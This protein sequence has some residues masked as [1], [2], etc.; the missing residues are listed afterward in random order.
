LEAE[1]IEFHYFIYRPYFPKK[2]IISKLERLNKIAQQEEMLWLEIRAQNML[3]NYHFTELKEYEKGF[4]YYERVVHLLKGT[5]P[6]EFPLKTECLFVVGLAHYHFHDYEQAV[7]NFKNALKAHYKRKNDY[8][9]LQ[10]LN[11]VGLCYRHLNKLDSS[12]LYFN[13]LHTYAIDNKIRIWEGIS[14]GNLGYNY[15]IQD[16]NTKAI[17]LIEI[18]VEIGKERKDWGVTA[19]GLLHLSKLKLEDNS[20]EEAKELIKEA[21]QYVDL[22][23]SY[24]FKAKLFP[25]LAKIAAYDNK[26]HLTNL[27]LDSA[28][29]VTDSLAKQSNGLMLIRAKQKVQLEQQK[30]RK[31][32]QEN[33]I[34][35]KN[36]I[37]GGL[38]LLVVIALL[39]LRQFFLTTKNR[40]QIETSKRKAMIKEL[41][42]F[43][44]SI[45]K[46]NELIDR[47]KKNLSQQNN[48]S[49]NTNSILDQ[50]AQKE[51]LEQLREATLLT[52]LE[53][54]A[55]VKM[56]EKIYPSFFQTLDNKWPK[57][58]PSEIR[59]LALTQL[60]V[61]NKEMA[62]MLGVG[63]DAI[64]Q[65]KSR[66]RKKT[67]LTADASFEELVERL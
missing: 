26:P 34:W 12:E 37:I 47:F 51:I 5:S 57:L 39:V 49:A 31:E 44:T 67:G 42:V 61:K 14:S 1:L 35:V 53:W 58:T 4:E 55:F 11:N 41:E 16:E 32:Q 43:K 21:T 19:S 10:S 65:V 36:L 45:S 18:E 40:K 13:K 6:K 64:R 27:Y 17:P 29:T 48:Q 66:L 56:F 22:S 38:S 25:L 20:I 54:N 2:L 50:D 24:A 28:F 30:R 59:F 8:Y 23:K 62:L 9:Y 63:T 33:R 15:Y 60:K 52:D 46:K 3:G 7:I